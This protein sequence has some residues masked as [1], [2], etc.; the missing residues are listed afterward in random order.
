MNADLSLFRISGGLLIAA[1]LTI[2]PVGADTILFPVLVSNA[3]NVTTIFSVVD[4]PTAGG[5]GTHL[6]YIY[7]YKDAFTSTRVPNRNGNCS[8]RTMT[9]SS[10]SGDVVSFDAAGAFNGGNALF[11]DANFYGGGFGLG[12][13]GPQRGYLLVRNTNASGTPV[14]VGDNVDLSGEFVV[15]E[16]GGGAAWGGKAVNDVDR[17]N[18]DF[19]SADSGGGVY[20][21]LPAQG[22]AFRRFTFAPPNEWSTR[23]FVTPIGTNME[24]AQL[25]APISVVQLHDRDG[26]ARPFTAI[27]LTVTC[28]AAVDLRDLVDSSTWAAVE[29]IGG[30]ASFGAQNAVVYKLEYSVD[31]Q[32]NGTVNNGFLLSD[33]ALP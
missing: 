30:W 14:L 11:G 31:P 1:G 32:Y 28:T 21:A 7:R 6:T 20:S 26:Q 4:G 25:S 3:P 5:G 29:N 8:T 17:E 13:T 24:S 23:F 19:I 27:A 10:F 18:Y 12:V 9:R 33:Y 22:V 2:Q 16:L 15:M